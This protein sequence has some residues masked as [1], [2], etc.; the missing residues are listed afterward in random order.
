MVLL[1]LLRDDKGD[2]S[3]E[4]DSRG[5][6]I[7]DDNGPRPPVEASFGFFIGTGEAC[8]VLIVVGTCL[9]LLVNRQVGGRLGRYLFCS[10]GLFCCRWWSV[11]CTVV[12]V[13]NN[14]F[15]CVVVGQKQLA[16][17]TQHLKQDR[18]M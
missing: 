1:L 18:T 5:V 13:M 8:G 12:S 15:V 9:C 7:G 4:G 16:S 11:Y 17:Q 6:G 2:S 3:K 10:F 14:M